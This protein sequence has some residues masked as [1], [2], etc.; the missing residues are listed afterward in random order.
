MKINLSTI[1][2]GQ[3]DS[4]LVCQPFEACWCPNLFNINVFSYYRSLLGFTLPDGDD[5][6][7]RVCDKIEDPLSQTPACVSA[8]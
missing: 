6:D 8:A 1:V 4:L 7:D 3:F 2:I 5:E